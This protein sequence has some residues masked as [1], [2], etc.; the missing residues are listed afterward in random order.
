MIVEEEIY[1]HLEHFGVAGMRWGVR[2][3]QNKALNRAS[4]AK[5]REKW[6][7]DITKARAE[8]KSGKHKAEWK[9]AK[10]QYQM[11]KINLGSREA[12][13]ILN[14]AREQKYN[15]AVTSQQAKTGKE[16]AALV[17]AG[18][19]IMGL[20]VALNVASRR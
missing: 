15:R 13:K 7:K 9:Q 20:G 5:D 4:R 8:V 16:T 18:V 3:S 12:K 19:G 6:N 2:N 17:L 11:D 14:K 1:E 10:A